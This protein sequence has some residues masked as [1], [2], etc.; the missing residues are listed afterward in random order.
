METIYF[1]TCNYRQGT[2]ATTAHA[3]KN[4]ERWAIYKAAEAMAKYI[5]TNAVLVPIPSHTGNAT[6]TLELAKRIARATN[7][8]VLD[9]LKCE[10]REMLYNLKKQGKRPTPRQMGFYLVR[11]IPENKRVI[12]LDNVVATGTTAAAA[13]QAVGKG[14]I[15]AYAAATNSDQIK[16]LKR[17]NPIH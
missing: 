13:V 14:I 11:S 12:I 16:G 17:I 7:A 10:P 2:N 4:G 6:Y 8:E 9:A 15:F 1:A 5:P 3:M